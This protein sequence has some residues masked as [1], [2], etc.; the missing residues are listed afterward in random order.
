MLLKNKACYQRVQVFLV[1]NK[2]KG[3]WVIYTGGGCN[4]AGTWTIPNISARH[5]SPRRW[6]CQCVERSR[7]NAVWPSCLVP[8]SSGVSKQEQK[9][10]SAFGQPCPY[11]TMK[12]WSPSS[13]PELSLFSQK[14]IGLSRSP[15]PWPGGCGAD[16]QAAVGWWWGWPGGIS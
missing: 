8:V 6:I 3:S 5:L 12:A 14:G 7:G 11:L 13:V 16:G 2:G 4:F 15:V 10:P 9:T 1:C